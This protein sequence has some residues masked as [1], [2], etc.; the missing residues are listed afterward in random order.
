M[1]RIKKVGVMSVAKFYGLMGIV[2]GF[3]IGLFLTFFSVAFIGSTGTGSALAEDQAA[4]FVGGFGILAIIIAPIL[5]GI[6]FFVIGAV[7]AFIA[8]ILLKITGGI[9]IELE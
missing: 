1:Q 2:V 9:E 8:N 6:L 3:L 4:T 5:Y 7:F